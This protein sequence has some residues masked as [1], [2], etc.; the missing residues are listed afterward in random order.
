MKNFIISLLSLALVSCSPTIQKKDT[1]T[2]SQNA[3]LKVG[4]NDTLKINQNQA[5][6]M[7]LVFC[8]D[9]TGS[10]SGLIHTAKEK[11]WDIV[12]VMSQSS[13]TPD[14]RLGMVFYRDLKDD[15]VTKIYPLT[16][17]IDSVYSEL[18]LIEAQGGGD[19]PESVNQALNEAVTQMGWGTGQNIYRT[20]FLVG[21]CPP[22]MDYQQDVKYLASCA[23]AIETGIVIN[24]IKLGLQCDD[25]IPHFKAIAEATNGEYKQLGQNADDVIVE[26]PYD[27]SIR[28]YSNKIDASKLYY[29]STVEQEAMKLKQQKA[30]DLYEKS[31]SNAVASRAKFNVSKAGKKNLYGNKE[32]VEELMSEKVKLEDIDEKELPE[33]I[34][35]INKD[36]RVLHLKQL[37]K[38]RSHN[39]NRLKELTKERADFISKRMAKDSTSIRFSEEIYEVV[40]HQAAEKGVKTKGE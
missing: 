36:D 16:G 33:K 19:S 31:S 6:I 1:I 9:A 24:T 14:I 23:M 17:D 3:A 8:L 32:L 11:I 2:L 25:A 35:I 27:D 29:G 5:P 12:T 7:E 28:H 22:H 37:Q 15:F 18:L 20:I 34:K 39:I 10:M 38:A 40:K 21:D 13:P 4:Q 30:L 26:T